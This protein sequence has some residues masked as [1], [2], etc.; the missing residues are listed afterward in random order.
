MKKIL[1]LFICGLFFLCCT[2]PDNPKEESEKIFRLGVNGKTSFKNI[3]SNEAIKISG[4]NCYT[5]YGYGEIYFDLL[6]TTEIFAIFSV[7]ADTF[8]ETYFYFEIEAKNESSPNFVLCSYNKESLDS[9]NFLLYSKEGMEIGDIPL[10]INGGIGKYMIKV[11]GN[12]K[13]H[14][15]KQENFIVIGTDSLYN[16][17]STEE[18][19]EYVNLKSNQ[20][21]NLSKENS[22]YIVAYPWRTIKVLVTDDKGEIDS[23]ETTKQRI[24]YADSVFKQ[25]ICKVERTLDT[26]D[27]DCKIVLSN[28]E[29][30]NVAFF[31]E[32]DR[33][34]SVISSTEY[35]YAKVKGD[36]GRD[37][38]YAVAYLLGVTLFDEK[39]RDGGERP[40]QNFMVSDGKG[41]HLSFKQWNQLH[42]REK[43]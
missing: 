8:V 4:K 2:K 1:L 20:I 28:K 40:E 37:F 33:E 29:N 35:R 31:D 14:E 32:T 19:K 11:S 7:P 43:K 22:A 5:N 16:T 3:L 30:K 6:D 42:I 23:A 39:K 12:L 24:A 26:T 13:K 18:I 34:Y 9:V 15:Y 27:Y 25:A 21:K 17:N 38:T 10:L 36:N 41:T